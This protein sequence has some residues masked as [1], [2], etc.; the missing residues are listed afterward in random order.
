MF[1]F[2]FT[3]EW[4]EERDRFY[5][6]STEG[7]D[8]PEAVQLNL[9]YRSASLAFNDAQIAYNYRITEQTTLDIVAAHQSYIVAR[10]ALIDFIKAKNT[11]FVDP[12]QE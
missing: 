1:E 2:S 8:D 5:V 7:T 10:R 3:P 12:D 6:L 11:E 4:R 9:D